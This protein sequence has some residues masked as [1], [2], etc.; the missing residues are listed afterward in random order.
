M[1]FFR[2]KFRAPHLG[3]YPMEQVKRVDKP[4]TRIDADKIKRVPLRAA[5]FTRPIFGD[6]GEKVKEERAR[7]IG[8]SPISEAIGE[9]MQAMIPLQ[10]GPVAEEKAPLTDD[11]AEMA[12]HM[13][14]LAYFMDMDIVGICEVPEYA[15]Y[16][17]NGKGEP[18]KA[19]HSHAIVCLIDQGF[20][21]MEGASGDDWISGTQSYRAYLRGA[22][23]GNVIANYIRKLGYEARCHSAPSGEVMQIP[24]MLLAGLGELSRIGELVL[25]PFIGPRSKTVVITTNLPMECDKPIDFGLQKFCDNCFKCA[26]ECPCNA[27]S[28]GPKIMYNGYEM[29]KPDVENCAKYRITNPKGSACGRCM[30]TCPLNKVVTKDGPLM[31]RIASWLGINAM[32]LKPL[33]IPI[34][35]WLDDAMGNGTRVKGQKWWLDIEN[36]DGKIIKARGVNERDI[37][38]KKKWPKTNKVALYLPE[39]HPPGDSKEPFP[40]DRKAALRKGDEALK[41]ENSPANAP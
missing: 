37:D 12:K 9:V 22:E 26:R 34:A 29:W 33:M 30:K 41:P 19:R 8:K 23:V 36:V 21:T 14:S 38:V 10:D 40:N 17:H 31:Q 18:V 39:D 24:L 32:W 15:W 27:I 25:N 28:F 5:F 16:T 13:K 35:V 20:E 4:T 2:H 11:P 7:F 3:K 1:T 6:L